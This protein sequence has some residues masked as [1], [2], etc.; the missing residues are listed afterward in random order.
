[1]N[2]VFNV[3]EGQVPGLLEILGEMTGR[4]EDIVVNIT[5]EEPKGKYRDLSTE[6]LEQIQKVVKE[7]GNGDKKGSKE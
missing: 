3:K 7:Q 6:D 2:V 5:E 4:V 1:M